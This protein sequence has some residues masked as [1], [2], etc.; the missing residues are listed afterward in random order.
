MQEM[1]YLLASP[2]APAA[3]LGVAE[4]LAQSRPQL[5]EPLLERRQLLEQRE[6]VFAC[7]CGDTGRQQLMLRRRFSNS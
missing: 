4:E 1:A 2:S 5:I 6:G 7:E 3:F